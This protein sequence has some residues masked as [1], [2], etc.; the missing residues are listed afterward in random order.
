MIGGMS[1]PPKPR[2]RSRRLNAVGPA[3]YTFEGR[4]AIVTGAASGMGEATA[5]LLATRGARVLVADMNT[6]GARRVAGEIG[7]LAFTVDVSDAAAC[8]AMV[9][10]A[11]DAYGRLDLA[12]NNAGISAPPTPLAEIPLER[13]RRMLGTHLD[14]VFFCMRSQIP[15]MLRTGG[16]AIVNT[17][18]VMSVL[19]LLGLA[20]YAAAKHG[21]L[22]LTRTAAIEY[23][24]QG[25]RVNCVGPGIMETPMTLARASHELVHR[26]A[27]V[28]PMAR[29]GR[30]EEMA[31]LTCFLLSDAASFCTGGWYAVDGGYSAQS[32]RP[33]SHRLTS[34]PAAPTD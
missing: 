6:E 15:A 20:D 23:S 30:P 16:G 32:G 25:I 14:G 18:S 24:A 8:E 9:V 2:S 22:G 10:A 26:S 4:V 21:I 19:G 28:H 27:S 12:V 3:S 5:R 1:Q 31:E 33:G 17:G 7:G 29:P 13:Y 11:L 34:Y